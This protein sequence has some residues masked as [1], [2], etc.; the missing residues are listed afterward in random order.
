MITIAALAAASSMMGAPN[1]TP[2]QHTQRMAWWNNARFGMFIHWGLYAVPAGKWGAKN[3]YGEWIHEEA[4]IPLPEYEKFEKQFNPVKFNAD[5]WAKMAKDAGMKYVVITTKHHDG[6]N[7]FK[8]KYSDWSVSSTPFKRDVMKEL[9]TAVRKQGMTMGW[10]HSIMDWHH[11]DYLPRRSWE[12]DRPTAGADMDRYVKYLHNEVTQLLKDYGPIGVLWFD[13]EWENTWTPKYGKELYDLCRKLQP[14]II[15]NNRVSPGRDGMGDASLK[16]GDY[17]TP[18]QYIPAT[19]LPGQDWETCMTMNGHWGYNAYDTNWKSSQTLIRNLVDICSKGGNYLLNVGPRADGTFPPEAV[20]RLHDIGAWMKVNGESIYG[21]TAS[22]FDV[23]PWGRS[24]TKRHGQRTT[25]YLS[26]FDWP[27][28]GKLVVPG[29]GNTPLYAKVLGGSRVPVVRDGGDLVVSVPRHGE[30]ENATVV[31]V[32][33]EGAPVIYKAPV[34]TAP[35][36]L[37]VNS[38]PVTIK[39]SFRQV[40]RYTLD[41]STPTNSSQGYH[42]AIQIPGGVVLKAASFVD[43]KRVS[44]VVQ[45]RFQRVKP[46]PAVTGGQTQFTLQRESYKGTWE[47]LPNFDKLSV[48][49]TDYVSTI[50]P[51]MSSGQPIEKTGLRYSGYVEVPEDSVY[52]FSLASDDGAKLWID[53]RLVVDNDGLHG[54]TTK[55]G[56]IALAKGAHKIVLNYFNGTGGAALNLKWATPG[57]D[58]VEIPFQALSH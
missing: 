1:D 11:P 53:G 12:K 14:N 58:A 9:S 22:E 33:V 51:P 18:E 40:V 34:I 29:V 20:A 39:A 36:Q 31:A 41:G 16:A 4:Q 37:V 8:S 57:K 24:T 17:G 25:L 42:R 6:F 45:S 48:D 50:V 13:G 19:G 27:K 30:N 47:K 55:T 7:L 44:S 38:V 54:A 35:T 5:T 21:T 2:A 43:G 46:L 3:G 28:D 49:E 26:V 32:T 23:L 10:Y 15:V 56:S 52:I